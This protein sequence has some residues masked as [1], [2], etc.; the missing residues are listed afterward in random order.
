VDNHNAK[1]FDIE[2]RRRQVAR[3]LARSK[4][5]IEI[6]DALGVD[7]TTI[8]GDIKALRV[9]SQSFIFDLAKSDLG[10]Y[11][12]D[13]LDSIEE[14]KREAWMIYDQWTAYSDNSIDTAKV[15]LTALKVGIQAAEA[16]FKLLTE[17]PNIMAVKAM[18][19]RI[20]VI[21]QTFQEQEQQQVHR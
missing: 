16:K 10:S 12:K 4:S 2:E 20:N 5:Q 14:V 7:Q 17:G 13:C 19:D 9:M 11:Y 6:A 15:R 8:S 3:L 1:K 18:E 21:E